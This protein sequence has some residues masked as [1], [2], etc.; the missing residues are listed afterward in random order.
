[1][2]MTNLVTR[3]TWTRSACS[4]LGWLGAAV[5]VTA[6]AWWTALFPTVMANTGLSFRQ[7]LPCLASTSDLCVLE[8][9]L[10]GGRHLFGISHYSPMLFWCGTA[11]LS[12]SLFAAS[13]LPERGQ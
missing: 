11:L 5:I 8:T 12:A 1:M 2:S 4:W 10:C 13:L 3:G 7:A 9:A 6:F